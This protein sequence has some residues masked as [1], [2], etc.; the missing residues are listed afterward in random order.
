MTVSVSGLGY[1]CDIRILDPS[2]VVARLR[3]ANRQGIETEIA[4]VSS[5]LCDTVQCLVEHAAA[6]SGAIKEGPVWAAS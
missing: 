5:L 3:G 6:A 1:G 4:H 2:V